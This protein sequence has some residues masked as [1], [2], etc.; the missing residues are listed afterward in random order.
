MYVAFSCCSVDKLKLFKSH[1]VYQVDVNQSDGN[2]TPTSPKSS[3]FCDD[4]DLTNWVAWA[5]AI[6]VTAVVLRS[7]YIMYM[8]PE[9]Y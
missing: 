2:V 6:V 7:L 4:L 9:G 3:G 1:T 8:K 5:G